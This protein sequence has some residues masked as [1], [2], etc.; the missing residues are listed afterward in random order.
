MGY[1][2]RIEYKRER[3]NKVAETLSRKWEGEEAT[4]ALISFSTAAWIDELKQSYALSNEI[5]AIVSK[6]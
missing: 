2:L 3:D 1:N 5:H 4:L 6:Q